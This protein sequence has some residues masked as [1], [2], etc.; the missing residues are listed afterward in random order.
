MFV[1]VVSDA[2]AAR[3]AFVP[4]A[5]SKKVFAAPWLWTN[6]VNTNGVTAKIH[7]C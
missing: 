3:G 5:L 6:G 2:D 4:G 7:V 1:V